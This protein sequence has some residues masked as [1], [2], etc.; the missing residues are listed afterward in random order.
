MY[1]KENYNKVK[2][3]ILERRNEAI[4]GAEARAHHVRLLN[5]EIAKIDSEL[6]KTGLLI[7]KTA[8][9]G[10]SIDKIR[11]RNTELTKLRAREL[12]KIGYPADY[13]EVKYT[14]PACQDTGFSDAGMC[15]CMRELLIKE[16]IASSGIGAL[17][18]RQSFENFD[19]S[20]Y[21]D[22]AKNYEEMKRG[23][24]RAKSY[25]ENFKIPGSPNLLI[26]GM[27]GTGK[28]HVSTAIAKRVIER[29]YEVLYD[30]AQN[31]ID[32]FENDKFRRPYGQGAELQGEKFLECD[33]LI[34]DDL[35]T[36]FTTPFALSCLYNILNTRQNKGLPTVMSTNLTSSAFNSKYEDRIYSRMVGADSQILIFKGRDYRLHR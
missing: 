36:E 6:S 26:M 27:T 24:E 35:G 5:P 29:G 28:T 32:A 20:W 8:C 13:T 18:D 21:G 19:L 2:L 33:L 10:E 9:A 1:G 14:C 3:L 23:F 22:N 34:I 11:E 30:T 16:N 15:S 7:F 25:A 12:E 17:M 4:A 31:I